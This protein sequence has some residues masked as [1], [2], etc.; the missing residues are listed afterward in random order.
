MTYHIIEI[1]SF[2]LLFV[3]LDQCIPYC[4][5]HLEAGDGAVKVLDHP[6]NKNVG[7][8]LVA[9]FDLPK[10]YKFIYWGK[11]IPMS[12]SSALEDRQIHFLLH[13]YKEYGVVDPEEFKGSVLQFAAC[14]GPQEIANM[15]TTSDH[16]GGKNDK[17]VG[18]VYQLAHAVKKDEQIA[19]HYG[20][21]W[22]ESRSIVRAN[23]GTEKYP[24]ARRPPTL[25]QIQEMKH[26]DKKVAKERIKQKELELKENRKKEED[27]VAHQNLERNK[28]RRTRLVKNRQ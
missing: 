7:K 21:E 5:K 19:H 18:R 8:I 27:K 6:S 10:G 26:N 3:N 25:R 13:G 24:I 2:N 16:F 17:I 1:K 12:A 22:F 15:Y 20:N 11:R 9:R 14:P 23:V 4:K 28:R